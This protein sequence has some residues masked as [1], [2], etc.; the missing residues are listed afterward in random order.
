MLSSAC[1]SLGTSWGVGSKRLTCTMIFTAGAL[2]LALYCTCAPAATIEG[3]VGAAMD[4]DSDN[5][6]AGSSAALHPRIGTNRPRVSAAL[7]WTCFLIAGSYIRR[8]AAP[9][10]RPRAAG[11]QLQLRHS[12]KDAEVD[13]VP[14]LHNSV[15]HASLSSVTVGP[16]CGALSRGLLPPPALPHPRRWQEIRCSAAVGIVM[17]SWLARGRR[18]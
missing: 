6:D 10:L 17:R 18:V 9:P 4:H 1:C 11:V 3:P 5:R 13:A 12:D 2:E 15:Q 14:P 8:C 7:L 16:M